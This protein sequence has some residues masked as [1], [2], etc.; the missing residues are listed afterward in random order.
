MPV[1]GRGWDGRPGSRR[2]TGTMPKSYASVSGWFWRKPHRLAARQECKTVVMAPPEILYTGSFLF[3]EGDAAAARVLGIAK[4]LRESGHEVILAGGEEQ[5]GN[6]S[7]A[8]FTCCPQGHLNRTGNA[9]QHF[10]RSASAGRSAL[11]RLTLENRPAAI[12]AYD[13][14][15]AMLLRLLHYARAA[16]I[17][18]I[19]DLTEWRSE[20]RRV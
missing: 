7:F 2:G 13:P 19:L 11:R 9:L 4:A 3:P 16:R 17:P 1:C 18:L 15:T 8:G 10:I 12:L 14:P 5:L 6:Y 20:E